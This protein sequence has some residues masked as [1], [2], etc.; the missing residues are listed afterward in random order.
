MYAP[1]SA[2]A[3]NRSGGAGGFTLVELV[4]ALAIAV[5][6]LAIVPVSMVKLHEAMQYRSA[7]RDLLSG[8]KAAR[9]EAGR[10]GVP[11]PLTLD[12]TAN[13]FS[14]GTQ[15]GVDL[16]ATLRFGL[17]VAD[18]ELDGERGSIRFYPDGS[19]TGGSIVVQRPSGDGVRLRVDWL[20][21]RVTQEPST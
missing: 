4:V 20:L 6:V 7:V 17:I 21:G 2:R 12:I 15:P 3:G 19:S 1:S 9:T 11:V 14:V 13:R 5:I 18:R 8:L 10:L 16:P